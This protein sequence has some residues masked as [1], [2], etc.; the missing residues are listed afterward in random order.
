MNVIS[1]QDVLTDKKTRGI[2]GGSAVKPDFDLGF[3]ES[4]T[5]KYIKYSTNYRTALLQMQC[6]SPQSQWGICID[7]KF[8]L[9]NFR[10]MHDKD[11]SEAEKR[12]GKKRF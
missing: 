5:V 8:P 10:R 7:S 12:C 1:L 6:Y 2:F 9:E 11:L 4:L 3:G